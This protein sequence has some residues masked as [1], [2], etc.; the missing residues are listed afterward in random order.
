M[1]IQIFVMNMTLSEVKKYIF[2]EWRIFHQLVLI[3]HSRSFNDTVAYMRTHVISSNGEPALLT[4]Y[5]SRNDITTLASY[6]RHNSD[7]ILSPQCNSWK[8]I[9]FPL[10]IWLYKVCF[11]IFC[12]TILS[13]HIFKHL[14]PL[15]PRLN[16]YTSMKRHYPGEWLSSW[17]MIVIWTCH[18]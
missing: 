8:V 4:I 3:T 15:Y 11:W 14:K 10:F 9:H 6:D 12:N 5:S 7:S 2:H 18:Q 13:D 16:I 17:W 1:D